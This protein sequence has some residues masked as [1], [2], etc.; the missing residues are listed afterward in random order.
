ML[1]PPI[2]ADTDWILLLR[3]DLRASLG[4]KDLPEEA[5]AKFLSLHE[6][7]VQLKEQL[8]TSQ[9]KLQKAR[10]VSL[11]YIRQAR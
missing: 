5:K 9:E 4:G 8:K 6:D 2:W 10:A 7:N 11:V 3:R 1:W